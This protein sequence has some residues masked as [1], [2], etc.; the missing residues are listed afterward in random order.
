MIGQPIAGHRPVRQSAP[1]SDGRPDESPH[2]PRGRGLS[3]PR[4]ASGDL[5]DAAH[6]TASGARG[7]RARGHQAAPTA[8]GPHRLHRHREGARGGADHPSDG[9]LRDGAPTADARSDEAA[10][11][12]RRVRCGLR[13]VRFQGGRECGRG[14]SPGRRRRRVHARERTVVAEDQFVAEGR[15]ASGR[16]AQ[17]CDRGECKYPRRWESGG[18]YG[19][20]NVV[21]RGTRCRR[22]S[23]RLVGSAGDCPA[24]PGGG[25]HTKLGSS[26]AEQGLPRRRARFPRGRCLCAWAMASTS[27][28][29]VLQRRVG[30][31]LGGRTQWPEW[32]GGA[33]AGLA[34]RRRRCLLPI[35]DRHVR[36]RERHRQRQQPD[37]RD[38]GVHTLQPP[39]R[40]TL[41]HSRGHL[42][43]RRLSGEGLPRLDAGLSAPRRGLRSPKQ[44]TARSP[45]M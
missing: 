35:G 21:E 25:E 36:L 5:A 33:A 29:N 9:A 1:W 37:E 18:G 23:R 22:D 26:P 11:R 42:E 13:L 14:L 45:S 16:G 28:H 20:R 4:P 6:R 17:A 8:R 2:A 32:R 43:P 27:A 41:G 30:R 44:K 24:N 10:S 38:L 3:A 12:G 40:A 19:P 15:R 31:T 34:E 39:L 7:A